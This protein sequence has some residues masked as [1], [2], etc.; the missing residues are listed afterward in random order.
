MQML[1][2]IFGH[3]SR[4]STG[5]TADAAKILIPKERVPVSKNA[6]ELTEESG[7]GSNRVH[8]GIKKDDSI[9][10]SKLDKVD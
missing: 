1:K 6:E 4:N 7:D 9:R 10:N 5:M 3:I 8:S 2:R